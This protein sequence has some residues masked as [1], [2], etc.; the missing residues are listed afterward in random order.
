MYDGHRLPD[1]ACSAVSEAGSC[2]QVRDCGAE[3]GATV[4]SESSVRVRGCRHGLLSSSAV[5]NRD[6]SKASRMGTRRECIIKHKVYSF[7][8]CFVKTACRGRI[9]KSR[10]AIQDSWLQILGCA[11]WST[12]C[13]EGRVAAIFV[14][15]WLHS[16]PIRGR[17]RLSWWKG[18]LAKNGGDLPR[19]LSS[20]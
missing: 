14:G 9:E 13:S 2:A 17:E 19:V 20:D 6:S 8:K 15:I 16:L 7:Y 4:H 11:G 12:L 1:S 10:Q 3:D 18:H 5:A